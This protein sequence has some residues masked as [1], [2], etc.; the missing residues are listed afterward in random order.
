[1]ENG[2][3]KLDIMAM[4]WMAEVYRVYDVTSYDVMD[5]SP[6]AG[7]N[8]LVIRSDE[9]LYPRD[10][11]PLHRVQLDLGTIFQRRTLPLTCLGYGRAGIVD[12]LSNYVHVGHMESQDFDRWTH[13]RANRGWGLWGVFTHV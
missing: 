7:W 6:Q 8:F 5:S 2:K 10:A 9:F 1:M 11:T 3:Q 13:T 4:H 12:K